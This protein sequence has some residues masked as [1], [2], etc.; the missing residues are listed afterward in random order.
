M[1]GRGRRGR[2]REKERGKERDEGRE[3]W[4]G[5]EQRGGIKE[6]R[7]AESPE[8]KDGAMDYLPGSLVPS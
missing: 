2:G 8:T 5:R 3:V 7:G 4:G 1:K 6:Q